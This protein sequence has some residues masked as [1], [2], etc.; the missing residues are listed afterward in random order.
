MITNTTPE[1]A[2][3]DPKYIR[4]FLA[5]MEEQRINLHAVLMMRGDQIFFEKYW[6]P[7]TAGF[8]HRMYM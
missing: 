2:G 3:L 5:K 8:P 4:R 7:F 6:A 1:K